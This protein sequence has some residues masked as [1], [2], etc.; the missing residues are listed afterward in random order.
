MLYSTFKSNLPVFIQVTDVDRA[1]HTA[2]FIGLAIVAT[3]E[4]SA[5]ILGVWQYRAYPDGEWNNITVGFM[6]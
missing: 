6:P 1:N 4:G 5:D 2:D 3:T